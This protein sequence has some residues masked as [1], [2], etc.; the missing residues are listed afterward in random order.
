MTNAL[1]ETLN[2]LG[3]CLGNIEIQYAYL[4]VHYANDCILERRYSFVGQCLGLL[5]GVE[6][7][8][9]GLGELL[10]GLGVVLGWAWAVLGR[11]W[12]GLGRS[13][14]DLGATFGAIQFSIIFLHDFGRQKGAKREAFW[15]PKWYQNRSK[16]EVEIYE[17]KSCLLGASW[18]DFG[19][20]RESLG[21]NKTSKFIGGASIS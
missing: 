20:F 3:D 21:I 16:N 17:R 18:V 11:S 2:K 13:W 19:S 9:G 15:E 4:F 8:L 7:I 14:G 6:G 5:G 12:G 1:L 10:G